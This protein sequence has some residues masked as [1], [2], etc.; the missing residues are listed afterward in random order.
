MAAVIY[1]FICYASIVAY[2]AGGGEQVASA[3][4]SYFGLAISYHWGAV[5]FVLLFYSIIFLGSAITG[6]VNSA[7]FI[8]MVFA[9]VMLVL[10][11]VDDVRPELLGRVQWIGSFMA[12]PLLL[13]SF[14]FQTM[15]PSLVPYL[16][17]N[18]RAL[19]Y[20][21]VGG[22]LI[23]FVIYALWQTLMLGIVPLEGEY[24]LME[25]YEQGKPVNLFL[26]YHVTGTWVRAISEYFAFFAI[27][28]SFLGL[29]FGLYDFIADGLNIGKKGW[30]KITISLLIVVP[31]IIAATQLE[32][33]FYIAMDVSGGFG[34]TILNGLIPVLMLW[35]G[36]YKLGFKSEN[37]LPIGKIF[38]SLVFLF[39]LGAIA[40]E[41]A[42]RFGY[43]DRISE[44]RASLLLHDQ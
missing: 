33:I 42:D 8:A 30:G 1:L 26:Q 43:Y 10:F 44:F 2:T 28:T 37:P 40:L 31:T 12:I 3:F 41:V 16:K 18:I 27:G 5:L 23:T 29:T 20:S 17:N 22:T 34:D 15:V 6:R 19:R 14:S 36:R 38:L 11:G 4:E 39:Y 25:A 32:R 21:I 9:Y 7:L 24:G 35:I 13:T